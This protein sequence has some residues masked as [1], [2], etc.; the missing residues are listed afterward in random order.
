MKHFAEIEMLRRRSEKNLR[1]YSA[2]EKMQEAEEHEKVRWRDNSVIY[3]INIFR[4]QVYNENI[5]A[6][7]SHP[8][9]NLFNI[10]IILCCIT[11]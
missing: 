8:I 6:L 2:R 5:Q 11:S 4:I 9:H 7:L 1:A 10:V 3:L